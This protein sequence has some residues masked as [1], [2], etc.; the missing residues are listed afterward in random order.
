MLGKIDFTAVKSFTPLPDGDYEGQTDSFEIKP[1]KANDSYNVVAKFKV[2]YDEDG[3]S[4][5]RTII[6]NWNLKPQSL[7]R[8]KRDLI[9]IGADPED[10]EGD[11]VDLEAVLGDLFGATPTPVT[12][13]LK[14]NTYRRAGDTEDSV[15]NEVT[16]VV[17]R[18]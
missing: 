3:S 13:S 12:I 7:W 17:A 11:D 18:S 8:I 15:N 10:L 4:K 1:T 16:K 5:S 14:L 9:A 2:D 6:T